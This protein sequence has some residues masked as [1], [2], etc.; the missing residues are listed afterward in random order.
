M[1][2][3]MVKGTDRKA[4]THSTNAQQAFNK[5]KNIVRNIPC[6]IWHIDEQNQFNHVAR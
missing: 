2:K 6:L 5:R 4:I 1:M 3:N